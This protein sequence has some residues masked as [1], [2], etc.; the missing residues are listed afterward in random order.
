M[1]CYGED[2]YLLEEIV[3]GWFW[4]LEGDWF[5]GV[6]DFCLLLLDEI[7]EGVCAYADAFY[8]IEEKWELLFFWGLGVG[9]GLLLVFIGEGGTAFYWL[10]DH[11]FVFICVF[12]DYY[13]FLFWLLYNWHFLNIIK[14]MIRKNKMQYDHIKKMQIKD[15]CIIS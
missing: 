5:L 2:F 11:L 10:L 9:L 6:E 3:L 1:I 14:N 13:W 4:M 15:N 8:F 12:W 7:D